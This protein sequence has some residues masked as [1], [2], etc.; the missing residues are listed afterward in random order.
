[1]S[2]ESSQTVEA[3]RVSPAELK[4][5]RRLRGLHAGNHLVIIQVSGEGL[6]ALSVL[7]SSKTERLAPSE[8]KPPDSG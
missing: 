2:D 7:T 4:L 3:V 5:L 6:I 1:M 8:K